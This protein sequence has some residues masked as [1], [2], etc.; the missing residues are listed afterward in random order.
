M[1]LEDLFNFFLGRDPLGGARHPGVGNGQFVRDDTP[2][3]QKLHEDQIEAD[4][5]KLLTHNSSKCEEGDHMIAFIPGTTRGVKC[6][7]C[8][9]EWYND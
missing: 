6:I 2:A 8:E 4:L 3:G 1:A 9:E 7:L 5:R